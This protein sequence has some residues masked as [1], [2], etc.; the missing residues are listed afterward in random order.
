MHLEIN[1]FKCTEI[2]LQCYMTMI[3][4]V[5]HKWPEKNC[6]SWVG[7]SDVPGQLAWFGSYQLPFLEIFLRNILID[8][9][10]QNNNDIKMAMHQM[11]V[12]NRTLA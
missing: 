1:D 10:I 12:C 3:D 8:Q 9:D 6:S 4:H 5:L 11:Y 7:S 2:T